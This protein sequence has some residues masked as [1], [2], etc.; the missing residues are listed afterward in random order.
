MSVLSTLWSL[1]K[2]S[3]G[4]SHSPRRIAARRAARRSATPSGLRRRSLH[5]ERLEPRCLLTT[6]PLVSVTD[7]GW[8]AIADDSGDFDFGSASYSSSVDRTFHVR[9]IGEGTLTLSPIDPAS[10]GANYTLIQNFSATVLGPDDTTQFIVRFTAPDTDTSSS[11]SV[12][13]AT[14]APGSPEYN[15]SLTGMG[16]NHAP[17]FSG[18]GTITLPEDS[19]NHVIDLGV[20]FQDAEQSDASLIYAIVSNSNPGLFDSASLSGQ[21]LTLDLALNAVGSASLV[22]SATDYQGATTQGT[23]SITVMPIDDAPIVTSFSYTLGEYSMTLSG[24]VSDPDTS[25]QN[26]GVYFNGL[27]IGHSG[28][29]NPD[30][31]FVHVM[32]MPSWAGEIGVKARTLPSGPESP[33]WMYVMY[34]G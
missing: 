20:P 11:G 12:E 25:W 33:N 17:M 6:S 31:T 16:T 10:L 19:P 21:Y 22:V 8:T 5:V 1:F 34:D 23:L 4:D 7:Q 27:A 13:F 24:T 9:N 29:V 14:S 2:D 28:G 18:M 32:E 26:L 30:Y 15:F 3:R